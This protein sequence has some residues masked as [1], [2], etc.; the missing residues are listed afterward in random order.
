MKILLDSDWCKLH[1]INLDYDLLK[2]NGEFSKP[3]I[4]SKTMTKIL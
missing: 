2:D 4:S 3:M 1:N